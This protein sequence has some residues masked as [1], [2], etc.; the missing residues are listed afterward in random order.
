M[1]GWNGRREKLA[2]LDSNVATASGPRNMPLSNQRTTTTTA[3]LPH[4]KRYSQSN[5]TGFILVSSRRREERENKRREKKVREREREKTMA[6]IGVSCYIIGGGRVIIVVKRNSSS[7]QV[8]F[9][10]FFLFFLD[11]FSF[12][13]NK[14][15]YSRLRRRIRI[16]CSYRFVFLVTARGWMSVSVNGGGGV[17]KGGGCKERRGRR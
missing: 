8:R 2:S 15:N 10:F 6:K 12:P 14:L 4:L 17:W 11:F 9:S 13:S 3:T 5:I 7:S 16:D 1:V